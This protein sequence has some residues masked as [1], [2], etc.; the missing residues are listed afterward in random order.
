MTY[1]ARVITK[2]MATMRT[3]RTSLVPP[4]GGNWAIAGRQHRAANPRITGAFRD[5]ST[6]G[7]PSIPSA[8]DPSATTV[9]TS[10][11]FGLPEAPNVVRQPQGDDC[12]R[13]ERNASLGPHPDPRRLA[14]DSL[15]SSPEAL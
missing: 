13:S 8:T 14:Q 6:G 7:E 12:P 2:R 11:D 9:A 4:A 5:C 3:T 15:E 1:T 10:V